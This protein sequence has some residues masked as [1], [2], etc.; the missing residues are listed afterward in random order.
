MK[1]VPNLKVGENERTADACALSTVVV[2]HL[3]R[4]VA[5]SLQT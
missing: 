1:L 4:K 2:C 3:E 5:R